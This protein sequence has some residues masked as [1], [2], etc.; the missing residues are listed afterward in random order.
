MVCGAACATPA[1]PVLLQIRGQVDPVGKLLE[2]D[3]IVRTRPA[4][5]A[6]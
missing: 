5:M 4:N 6:E 1:Q 3:S 2:A